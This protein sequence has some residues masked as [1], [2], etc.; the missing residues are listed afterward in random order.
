MNSWPCHHPHEDSFHEALGMVGIENHKHVEPA[1]ESLK[2]PPLEKPPAFG[3]AE[4]AV[5]AA[6]P[7][8]I[9]PQVPH[10]RSTLTNLFSFNKVNSKS[11]F[12]NSEIAVTKSSLP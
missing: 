4:H 10:Q 6:E 1:R 11:Y 7:P 5:M 9:G 3:D 2:M 12:M 8:S